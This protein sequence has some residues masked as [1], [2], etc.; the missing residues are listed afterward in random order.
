FPDG[1]VWGVSTSA[2]QIERAHTEDGRGPSIWDS[3]SDAQDACDH[4][5]RYPGDVRLMKDLGLAAYRLS[6]SWPRVLPEGS[7]R[8]NAAGLEYY[9]CLVD[10]LL[11]AGI[12]PDATLYRWDPS[13]A[14]ED[15]GGWPG[16]DTSLR[17]ADFARIVHELLGDRVHT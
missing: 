11:A 16:R 7:R 5:H 12:T 1:F 10:E 13:Q 9:E 14:L 17:F 15:R 8:V 6:V 4:Y 2:Y 3:F